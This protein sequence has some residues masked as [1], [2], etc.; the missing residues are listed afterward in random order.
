M[1][2]TFL[3][4]LAVTAILQFVIT[5]RLAGQA[6]EEGS[7][8]RMWLMFPANVVLNAAA[9]TLLIAVGAR[10]WRIVHRG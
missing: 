2:T 4:T 3:K 8:E 9:W 6:I 7:A 10:G 1:R 5:R